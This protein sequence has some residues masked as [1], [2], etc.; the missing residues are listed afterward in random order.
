MLIENFDYKRQTQYKPKSKKEK[1]EEEV[2]EKKKEKKA[3]NK[4]DIIKKKYTKKWFPIFIRSIDKFS[5]SSLPLK[6]TNIY[7]YIPYPL[8]YT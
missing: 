2:Q 7:L 3:E 4:K 1:M 6:F 8:F 5:D